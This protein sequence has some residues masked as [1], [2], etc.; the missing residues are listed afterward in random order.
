MKTAGSVRTD[1]EYIAELKD[2]IQRC[3][4]Y[5]KITITKKI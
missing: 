2:Y 3:M 4:S 5:I 1:K